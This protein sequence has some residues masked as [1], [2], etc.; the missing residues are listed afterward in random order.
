MYKMHTREMHCS[1]P[2]GYNCK[3]RVPDAAAAQQAPRPGLQPLHRAARRHLHSLDNLWLAK[4][5]GGCSK[6]RL[7]ELAA[8]PV[9]VVAPRRNGLRRRQHRWGEGSR[10]GAER[11][12]A[13]RQLAASA[14]CPQQ[15]HA[16]QSTISRSA[17]SGKSW[18]LAEHTHLIVEKTVAERE[19][20]DAAGAQHTRDFAKHRLR[21]L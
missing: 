7:Y 9:A 2:V 3:E 17:A 10:V 6:V 12:E 18:Q 11:W 21:L 14:W 5:A 19:D 1:L 4:G 20:A 8:P 15:L 13:G 16:R